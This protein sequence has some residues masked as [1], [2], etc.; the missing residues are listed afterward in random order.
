MAAVTASLLLCTHAYLR[1]LSGCHQRFADARFTSVLLSQRSSIC[2]A[3]ERGVP[4]SGS[5]RASPWRQRQDSAPPRKGRGLGAANR[6]PAG[7]EREPGRRRLDPVL[8]RREPLMQVEQPFCACR[9]GFCSVGG[10][11]KPLILSCVFFV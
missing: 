9:L 5:S 10:S 4:L 2:M 3:T 1:F 6:T 7:G 11:A 8:Q